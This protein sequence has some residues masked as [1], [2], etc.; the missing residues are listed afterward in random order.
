MRHEDSVYRTCYRDAHARGCNLALHDVGV[1][2]KWTK[3]EGECCEQGFLGHIERTI[4]PAAKRCSRIVLIERNT[5]AG[6][7]ILEANPSLRSDRGVRR[8]EDDIADTMTPTVGAVTA[9]PK[10][11]TVSHHYRSARSIAYP[12]CLSKQKITSLV[13]SR[14][15]HSLP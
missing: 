7:S 1:P 6:F 3:P 8:R 14:A 11:L 13:G 5:C 4:T 9:V 10:T 15:H 2:S 12:E